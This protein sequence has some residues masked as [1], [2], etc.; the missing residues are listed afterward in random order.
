V[1]DRGT[2][3]FMQLFYSNLLQKRGKAEA[4]RSAMLDLRNRYAHPYYWAP[5]RI[6]GKSL[7]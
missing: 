4:L 5:F 6:I 3:E 7:N 2:A 1:D